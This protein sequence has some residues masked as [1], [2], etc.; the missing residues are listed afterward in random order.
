MPYAP[1]LSES[2]RLQQ[3]IYVGT[4]K[5]RCTGEAAGCA[6]CVEEGISCVYSA[7]KRMGRPRKRR[8]WEDDGAGLSDDFEALGSGGAQH[9]EVLQT[10]LPHESGGCRC[11]TSY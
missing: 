9:G 1:N 8:R 5:L 4:R 6:R 3:I 10:L 2:P 11:Q 7:R